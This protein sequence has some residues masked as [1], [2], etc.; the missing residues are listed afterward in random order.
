MTPVKMRQMPGDVPKGEKISMMEGRH[1][2]EARAKA[3]RRG[4][5]SRTRAVLKERTMAEVRE[6][7]VAEGKLCGIP[8]NGGMIGYSGCDMPWGH[9]GDVHANAGDGF[10]SRTHE[11]EHRR[12]QQELKPKTGA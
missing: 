5:R 12:R 3:F 7:D 2:D 4:V 6:T 1:P 10:Y 9:D 11:A 8:A